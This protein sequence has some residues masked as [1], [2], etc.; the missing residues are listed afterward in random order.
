MMKRFM[1]TSFFLVSLFTVMLPLTAR[2]EQKIP[3]SIHGV[4]YSNEDFSFALIDPED[5][6]N[7][8]SGELV[9][10][11]SGGGIV[12]CY[13]LPKT[14]HPGIKVLIKAQHW[15][16]RDANGQLPE[17]KETHTV[18]VP[19]YADDKVSDLWVLR[20][21]DG[22]YAVVSSRY[23]PN[24]EKWPGT[25]KGWPIPSAEYKRERIM[26]E[27]KETENSIR[28]LEAE[29]KEIKVDSITHA[30]KMWPALVDA[31][32]IK[33]SDYTG[34]EDKKFQNRLKDD[35]EKFLKS[36]REKLEYLRNYKP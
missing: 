27:I 16:K 35:T 36:D 14:W 31:G 24:H 30:R 12:C 25:I 5:P 6:K 11:F 21:Q 10:R 8:G 2:A 18:E 4:N 7:G 33:A 32:I 19:R 26:A 13:A 1:K 3:V 29:E 22:S 34:P 23:Q 17:I 9:G 28:N 15:L 20:Q